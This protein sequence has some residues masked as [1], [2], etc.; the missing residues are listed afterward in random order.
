MGPVLVGATIKIKGTSRATV[1]NNAGNFTIAASKNQTLVVSNVGY[2][3]QEIIIGNETTINVNMTRQDNSISEVVV[4]AVGIRRSEK[5]LG[6]SVSKV[7]PDA[8]IQKSEPD[9]LK[10]MQGKVAGVDIRSSQGTPGSA[11][12]IQ[13]RGNS[14][15]FGDNQ[16]L[17]VVD[18]IPFSNDQIT[19]SNQTVGGTAYS[20]GISDLDP[21][22]IATLNVLKGSAAAALY[23]SRASNGVIIITTKSG[24]ATRNKKGLEVSYRSSFSL[25]Q[26]ANLPEYQ[27]QYGAGVNFRYANANGS[28]G[29]AFNTTPGGWR[30]LRAKRRSCSER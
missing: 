24:S 17:I 28:W 25:E 16:P 26:I 15:F 23:G 27:N 18:G 11:T 7:D 20:S 10:S 6:Y 5:A 13:L 30:H 21:N 22:D 1:T 9:L 14:S 29:P 4:T 12:R 8:L 19:T 3:E 2:A